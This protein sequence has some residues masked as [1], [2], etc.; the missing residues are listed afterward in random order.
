MSDYDRN[1]SGTVGKMEKGDVSNNKKSYLA[2]LLSVINKY[3]NSK[4]FKNQNNVP[5]SRKPILTYLKT[6]PN[7]NQ[8][9]VYY[10]LDK[11]LGKN[12]PCHS[13]HYM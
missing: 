2:N 10:Q 9:S 12:I 11:L 6:T 13:S 1:L 5:L 8:K 3:S 4:N 7:S